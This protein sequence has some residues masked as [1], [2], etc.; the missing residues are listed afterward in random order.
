LEIDKERQRISLGTKQLQSDP[1]TTDIPKKL[2]KGL[3]LEG[4]VA[5][6]TNFGVFIEVLDGLEGLLHVSEIADEPVEKPEE[7][8][9]IGQSVNVKVINVDFELRKIG[10]SMK[11]VPQA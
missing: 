11:G 3:V 9:K 1:W 5:K 4:K 7:L 8:L 6:I 10:L 2:V